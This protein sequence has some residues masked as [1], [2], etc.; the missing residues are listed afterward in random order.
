MLDKLIL[1]K[2]IHFYK[3]IESNKINDTIPIYSNAEKKNNFCPFIPSDEK[4]NDIPSLE[5]Y[6]CKVEKNLGQKKSIWIPFF[7]YKNH[8]FNL[9]RLSIKHI[10]KIKDFD[11]PYF[12]LVSDPKKVFMSIAWLWQDVL[13]RALFSY[14]IKSTNYSLFLNLSYLI[15]DYYFDDPQISKEDKSAFSKYVQNRILE[16]KEPFNVFTSKFDNA[17][18]IV[19]NDY[20]RGNENN[21]VYTTIYDMFMV[22]KESME[23]ESIRNEDFCDEKTI[24]EEPG[25]GQC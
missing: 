5:K 12:L 7:H 10:K 24:V 18:K 25:I 9:I 21:N 14:P 13:M 2:S 16:N 3:N 4:V 8:F 19:E 11:K 22:E 6:L 23:S 15:I 20:P 1:N 17:M